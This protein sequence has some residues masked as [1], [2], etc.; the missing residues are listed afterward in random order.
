MKKRA[1]ERGFDAAELGAPAREPS[2]CDEIPDKECEKRECRDC[3][4][5]P[6]PHSGRRA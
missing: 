2:A 3:P 5:Y 4:A 1:I 6:P